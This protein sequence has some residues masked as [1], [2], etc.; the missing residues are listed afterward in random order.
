M[1]AVSKWNQ[2]ELRVVRFCILALSYR[3]AVIRLL[4][5]TGSTA[6]LIEARLLYM[7]SAADGER[8]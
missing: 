2:A 8:T 4:M 6:S 7:S 1:K 3:R 5:Q